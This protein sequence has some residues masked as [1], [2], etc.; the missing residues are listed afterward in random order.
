MAAAISLNVNQRG[1]L[2]VFVKAEAG[3]RLKGV[4]GVAV[5]EVAVG[6]ERGGGVEVMQGHVWLDSARAA[7]G[8]QGVVEGNALWV[9]LAHAAIGKD[10]A[11]G[12]RHADAVHAEALA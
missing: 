2:G 5:E 4:D 11:P 3:V 8:E 12:D 1:Y 10:A 7:A 9:G 6:V